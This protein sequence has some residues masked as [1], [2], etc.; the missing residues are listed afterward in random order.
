M[1]S[2]TAQSI[3]TYYVCCWDRGCWPP[4]LCE[5]QCRHPHDLAPSNQVLIHN[6]DLKHLQQQQKQKQKKQQEQPTQ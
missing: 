5:W 1:V 4:H 2:C 6:N 3:G